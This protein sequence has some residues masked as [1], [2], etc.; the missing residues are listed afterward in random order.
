MFDRL[1]ETGQ[2][3][4]KH[5]NKKHYKITNQ[6]KMKIRVKILDFGKIVETKSF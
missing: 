3:K 5:N 6:N 2:Y 1:S 4:V